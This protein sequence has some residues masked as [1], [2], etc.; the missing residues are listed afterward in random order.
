M[1]KQIFVVEGKNDVN[2]LKSI[3]SNINVV[4]VGGSFI[5]K[6]IISY[7]KELKD[8]YEIIVI[9]D[10][11]FPGKKIRDYIDSEISGCKHIFL[12]PKTSRSKNKKKIGLEHV[13]SNI[14]KEKL[15]NI[16]TF[17]NEFN[18]LSNEDLINNKLIG[19]NNSKEL[20]LKLTTYLKIDN[21]N[22]KRLLKRLNSLNITSS[23]L[24]E[25][26]TKL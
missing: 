3:Y 13:D 2:K 8:N 9:T 16:I 23:K 5:D 22:G 7:L 11:D 18:E 1:K 19:F 12:E 10:P 14:I 4:S 15:N 24:K 21:C 17:N 26:M 25:I 6:N 20:R